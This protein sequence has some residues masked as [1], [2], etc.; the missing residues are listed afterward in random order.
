MKLQGKK[1]GAVAGFIGYIDDANPTDIDSLTGDTLLTVRYKDSGVDCYKDYRTIAEFNEDWEDYK[2][3][4]FWYIVQDGDI[5]S[6]NDTVTQDYAGRLQAIGNYFESKEE[7]KK[8]VEK[9]KAWKRLKDK[10]F[11]N[12]QVFTMNLNWGE[13]DNDTW[14][15]YSLLFGDEE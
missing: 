5:F 11:I 1:T 13:S 6:D 9:L 14:K 15:D 10:G 3:K 7:A 4:E 8:A 2:E 12:T